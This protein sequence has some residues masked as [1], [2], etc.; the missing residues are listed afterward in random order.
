MYKMGPKK[1]QFQ[2][3]VVHNSTY[4]GA[5]KKL[6]LLFWGEQ[7]SVIYVKTIY[8]AIYR[9]IFTL[10]IVGRGPTLYGKPLKVIIYLFE[11]E[12]MPPDKLKEW[13]GN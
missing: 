5:K 11:N 12:R 2:V 8:K 1:H 4:F 3:T 9:G 13:L 7:T 10:S 6:H